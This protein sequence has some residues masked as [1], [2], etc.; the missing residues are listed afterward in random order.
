LATKGIKG[1]TI[2]IGG[3]TSPLEKALQEVNSKSK[4]LVSELK[5]VDRLLKFDPANTELL[6]QK[7]KLLADSVSG[8]KEKLDTLKQ[9]EKQV[10]EQFKNGK[11]G[12]EQFRALQ[13]E[14]QKSEQDLRN[15]ESQA[16]KV[17]A[18]L[19]KDEAIGNLKKIGT[20]AA[21]TAVAV[22]AA[23][24]GMGVA[25]VNNA[26]ELQR[27]ADV[28]GL[29]AERLQELQYAG[30]NL[31]VELDTITGAQAKLTKSMFAAK[32]G[33]GSQADAFAALGISV[34]DSNGQMRDAKT[35]MEEAFTALN[36][37]GN[38]TE[39]DQLSMQLFGKS[40]MEMNPL[41][42]AGGDELNRLSEEAKNNGAVMSNEAVAGLDSFGDTID[43][44]KTDVLG[45]FGEKFAEILPSIQSFMD[46]LKE[47]PQWIKEN[48]TLLE[49]IGVI[50]GTVTA[51]IIAF[52]IQ[53][54]L[55]ASGL[56]LWAAIAGVATTVTTALGVAM[57]FLTG[58]IGLII[59]AIGAL[60][61]IFVVLWKNNEDLRNFFIETWTNIK[62]FFTSTMEGISEIAT[63]I[64]NGLSEL[65]S[66]GLLTIQNL[67]ASL[68][69]GVINIFTSLSSGIRSKISGIVSTIKDGLSSALDWISSLPDQMWDFGVN[70]IEG[71]I[72]GITSMIKNLK[73]IIKNVASEIKDGIADAL[74]INSPSKEMMKLGQYA[75][76]GL[77][78]GLENETGKIS[79]AM[80]H[81]SGLINTLNGSGASASSN[82]YNTYNSTSPSNSISIQNLVTIEGNVDES[83]MPK[84]QKAVKDG[85]K[86][87]ENALKMTGA[88]TQLRM[89]TI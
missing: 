4:D 49:V 31:G 89:G 18:V 29:S 69:N 84:V 20:V 6:A 38:E 39:R 41:I 34:L 3:N 5:Q 9:A 55:M 30:K 32:D 43:A 14:V 56:T 76:Q 63:N 61:A 13:R 36:N 40:A 8:T 44:L 50:I 66:T 73:K 15:L 24:V 86:E 48:S 2:D 77:A 65:F 35:V 33:T 23:F 17:N 7:Q 71:L 25:A 10:Q 57:T 37:V 45:A 28:T 22:G 42:K 75:T 82:I 85:I 87:L 78:I 46:K 12:E 59:L 83:T 21:G 1:I 62:D 68:K 19:S 53:Q 52:N 81:I 88:N 60:I 67:F 64:I 26:D 54:A 70:M 58:P 11:V 80:N 74:D 16:I 79:S 47:L 72:D 51:L 27:Q